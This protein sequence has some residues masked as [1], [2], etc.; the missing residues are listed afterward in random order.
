VSRSTPEVKRRDF[1]GLASQG[2]LIGAM[3]MAMVGLMKIMKP[4]V[5]PEVST[6]FK[7]GKPDGFAVGSR[8]IIPDRNVMIVREGDSFCA[9]SLVCTHL[10]CIVS[11]SEEGFAC[12][13]HG[14]KFD[15]AGTVKKGPAP[16]SL[17]WLEI[18]R[19]P[20][21]GLMVDASHPVPPGT[22][23]TT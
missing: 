3:G 7:I 4:K 22:K 8:T 20:A 14:S 16:K 13:C 19:L 6:A 15:R 23:Y 9:I 11:P 21:G 12:P 18:S 10:G 5:F 2:I 1:L 17:E